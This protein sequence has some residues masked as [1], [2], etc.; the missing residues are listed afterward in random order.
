MKRRWSIRHTLPLAAFALT[1]MLA[2]SGGRAVWAAAADGTAVAITITDSSIS[3]PTT[4]PAGFVTINVTNAGTMPHEA[5]FFKLNPGV[6]LDQLLAA[7]A[8]ADDPA[9]FLGLQQFGA[10]YGGPTNIDPGATVPIVLNLT[11]ATY[12]VADP[13]FFD[14]IPPVT[15][16][17][18]GTASSAAP[19]ADV[20]IRQRE[21]A[22]DVP[23]TVK[24]GTTRIQVHNAGSQVHEMVLIKLDPGYTLDDIKAAVSDPAS[25]GPPD[26]VHQTTSWDAQSTTVTGQLTVDLTPGTYGVLCFLPDTATGTPHALLGMANSFTVQ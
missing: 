10:F 15:F 7:S 1:A 12:G 17:V 24:A 18:S 25:E 2:V 22:F 14:Q 4:L 11:S 26:W 21:F 23:T 20:M 16:T 3:V 13:Q 9:V 5:S 6:T 8:N 19:P